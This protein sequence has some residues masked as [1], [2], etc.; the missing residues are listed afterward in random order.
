[1]IQRTI[2][3]LCLSALALLPI[4][5]GASTMSA[6]LTDAT[7][8][9]AQVNTLP[10][11]PTVKQFNEAKGVAL[12]HIAQGGAGLGGEGGGGLVLK[13]VGSGWG[14]PY[15]MDAAAGTIGLQL[16]GQTKDVLILFNN[17]EALNQFVAGGMQ[18]QAIA[19]GTAGT[20][21]GNS[22]SKK[23]A[24]EYF[25]R[26]DGLFGG[27]QLGGLNFSPNNKMNSAVY[28]PAASS[29]DILDGNVT[30]PDGLSSLTSALNA[31]K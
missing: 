23:L 22:A 11:K 27:A 9:L 18:L 15:A 28:G 21:S 25:V 31:I 2:V 4:G 24:Y 14:A 29:Q 20:D 3:T 30:K 10:H 5:C 8:T 16:G 6:R 12:M 17:A 7:A 19:E 26:G 13:R 1:M